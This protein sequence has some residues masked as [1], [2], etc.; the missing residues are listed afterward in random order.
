VCVERRNKGIG[1]KNILKMNRKLESIVFLSIEGK[2]KI[3]TTL[4]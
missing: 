1:Q 4:E 3:E 2:R